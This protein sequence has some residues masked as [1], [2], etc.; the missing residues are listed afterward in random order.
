MFWFM[1]TNGL[2]K[3]GQVLEKSEARLIEKICVVDAV[4]WAIVA[5]KNIKSLIIKDNS[6]LI[7]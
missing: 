5:D 6:K 4:G 7:L 3:K 1:L 2:L